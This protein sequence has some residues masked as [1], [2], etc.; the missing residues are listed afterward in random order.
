MVGEHDSYHSTWSPLP[1]A[2]DFTKKPANGFTR[3]Q[4]IGGAN[5]SMAIETRIA[6]RCMVLG[7]ARS[8]R[9]R[10]TLTQAHNTQHFL[11]AQPKQPLM[12]LDCVAVGH[13]RQIIARSAIQ[14]VFPSE[15]A[16]LLANFIR[17]VSVVM[18]QRF[19][20]AD[21]API[22][23]VDLR[24]EIQLPIEVAAQLEV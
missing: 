22:R 19:Q 24:V 4:R 2:S 14:A 13:A 12:F 8:T 10:R 18:K 1:P 15:L 3:P 17:M 21:S 11:D 9:K 16:G 23:F 5:S 6:C 7:Q 20:Q